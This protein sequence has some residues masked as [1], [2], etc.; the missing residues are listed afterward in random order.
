MSKRLIAL[1]LFIGILGICPEWNPG[2]NAATPPVPDINGW[3]MENRDFIHIK[4]FSD[5][6]VYLGFRTTYQNPQNSNEHVLVYEQCLL[7]AIIRKKLKAAQDF[8][9][10]GSFLFKKEEK[11]DFFAEFFSKSDPFIY[12]RWQTGKDPRTGLNVL[13]G[14]TEIWFLNQNGEWVFAADQKITRESIGE[15]LGDQKAVTGQ[16]FSLGANYHIIG[17]SRNDLERLMQT[18]RGK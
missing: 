10:A 17:I 6:T 3:K 18:R 16:K 12:E 11:P 5:T 1:V 9:D 2:A 7:Q 14:A 8:K 4:T 13:N 15:S